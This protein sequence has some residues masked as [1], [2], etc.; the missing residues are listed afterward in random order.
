[1]AVEDIIIG[2][3][4]CEVEMDFSV[5]MSV[6]ERDNPEHFRAALESVTIKQTVQPKQVVIVFDGPVSAAIRDSI[7]RIS[8]K[9]LSIEFSIIDKKKNAGLAVALNSGLKECKYAWVARMDSDDISLPD[10]FEK[11][12]T[13]IEQHPNISVFGGYIAEFNKAPGDMQSIRCVQEKHESIIR[14]AKTRTPFNHVSVMYRKDDVLNVGGYAED[15]GKLEDYRLWVDLIATN[16]VTGNILG[17]LVYV[18]VGNGF[19]ER[20][21][22]KREIQ[23]WDMLQLYL[24]N[25]GIVSKAKALKNKVYIRAFTYMPNKMKILAYKTIL[26]GNKE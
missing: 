8:G 7:S 24:V 19:I 16:K 10:R 20:R 11:Q 23:D 14:M 22:N 4:A 12:V 17:V 26:R 6:Y 3:L 13:Y 25:A 18:R 15:F 1:M 21:S 2:Y 5:L 9:T